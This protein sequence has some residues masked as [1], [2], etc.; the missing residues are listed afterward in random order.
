M[1]FEKLYEDVLT[2]SLKCPQEYSSLEAQGI[3]F[4]M[5]HMKNT[6]F[7]DTIYVISMTKYTPECTKLHHLIFFSG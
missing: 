4:N 6:T 5:F 7:Q 1:L 3:V 2:I